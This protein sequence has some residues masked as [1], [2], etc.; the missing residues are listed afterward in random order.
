MHFSIQQFL[1]WTGFK[2]LLENGQEALCTFVPLNWA[3]I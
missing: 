1:D 3:V 2:R